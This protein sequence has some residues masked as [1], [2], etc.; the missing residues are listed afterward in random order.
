MDSDER[1]R[2][3]P[4]TRVSWGAGRLFSRMM[5]PLEPVFRIRE[6]LSM[7]AR[8]ALS[9]VFL[10]VAFVLWCWA[11]NNPEWLNGLIERFVPSTRVEAGAPV[12][13]TLDRGTRHLVM[14]RTGSGRQILLDLPAP[15]PSALPPFSPESYPGVFEDA[16]SF[17]LGEFTKRDEKTYAAKVTDLDRAKLNGGFDPMPFQF[18]VTAGEPVVFALDTM[19]GRLGLYLERDSLHK[20]QVPYQGDRTRLEESSLTEVAAKLGV[21]GPFQR[22]DD[23]TLLAAVK[24]VAV[25][26]QTTEL[27]PSNPV[28]PLSLGEEVLLVFKPEEQ[29]VSAEMARTN[30][31][32]AIPITVA[33]LAP[34]A[35]PELSLS[36]YSGLKEELAS[37]GVGV[38]VPTEG[39]PRVEAFIEDAA[40]AVE[41]GF[42]LF[43]PKEMRRVGSLPSPTEVAEGLPVLWF[44]R[45][46]MGGFRLGTSWPFVTDFS[47]EHFR[48][49]A[50]FVT[51]KRILIGF[52]LAVAAAMPLGILMGSFSKFRHFFE[53]LRIAGLYLPLP[54]FVP[55]TLFWA[56]IGEGQKYAFLFICNF[57]VLLP[58]TIVAIE[59]VPQVFLDTSATL[60]LT[61]GQTVRRVLIGIAKPEIWKALR[62]T[63][64]IGWTWII[65]AEQI[66]VDNGL[67]YIIWTSERRS[68]PD[69]VYVVILLIMVLAFLINAFWTRLIDLLFPYER[70]R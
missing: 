2:L 69:H 52:G 4:I 22:K 3:S 64:G 27:G 29:S 65:L 51:M 48:E 70:S 43:R 45:N 62:F 19:R 47:W 33:K 16:R 24:D 7:P 38:R 39:P 60:G 37:E 20:A 10:L 46:L 44:D 41:R 53:P 28:E 49:S 15:A 36:A 14:Q 13:L 31:Q 34:E 18:P 35:L 58:Y 42:G 57:V 26:R 56:G 17:G 59:S 21:G 5:F 23:T 1:Q 8:S 61:R 12:T 55:L 50:V 40:K 9:L 6:D 67:G 66:G 30:K 68:H 11:T 63:F 54:A 32:R 25:F